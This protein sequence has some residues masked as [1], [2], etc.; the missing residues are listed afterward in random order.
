[1]AGGLARTTAFWPVRPPAGAARMSLE[2]RTSPFRGAGGKIRYRR[3]LPVDAHPG[4][5]LL[6]QPTAVAR[7]WTRERVFVPIADLAGPASARPRSGLRPV[8]G[9]R[10]SPRRG[11][12]SA[13]GVVS[14]IF[15]EVK[16]RP[17]YLIETHYKLGRR[18][19]EQNPDLAH[20]TDRIDVSNRVAVG[21]SVHS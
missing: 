15:D 4:E 12:I 5:G 21:R 7:L 6:S 17:R 9:G 19:E 14:L 3:V 1:M 13:S 18:V 2:G 20:T 8:Q 10:V 16:N 11:K